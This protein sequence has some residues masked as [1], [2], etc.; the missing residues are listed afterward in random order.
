MTTILVLMIKQA[1]L[2]Q[3][4]KDFLI[5]LKEKVEELVNKKIVH[6]LVLKAQTILNLPEL[7][8]KTF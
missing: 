4:K 1:V 6:L 7:Q 2:F 3:R 8:K 5:M